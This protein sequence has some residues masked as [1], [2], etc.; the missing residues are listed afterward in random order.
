MAVQVVDQFEGPSPLAD[1]DARRQVQ[2]EHRPVAG[3]KHRGLI[4]RGEEPVGI[5]RLASLERSLGIGHDN[6]SGE[7]LTFRT[8][9]VKN[10]RADA[11]EARH[12]S[13]REQLVLGG[14]MDDHIA[15]ARPDDRDI[16][17]ARGSLW[18]EVG[19]LDAA[20][21]VLLEGATAAEQLGVALDELVLGFAELLGARLAVELIEQW[22]GIEGFEVARPSRHEQEDHRARLGLMMRRLRA[23]RA[24]R[25][26]AGLLFPQDRRQRE[27]AKSAE[28]IAHKLPARQRWAR[29][30][31][32]VKGH[33]EIH[34]Y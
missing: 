30:K 1:L 19:N 21:T 22:L 18:E 33:T 26:G 2:I 12:D 29:V 6:V 24:R 11:R 14:R 20:L 7:R 31:V 27:A 13:S 17:D 3:S 5:H 23:E 15:V 28:G 32:K 25:T 8:K 4:D 34:S 16:V 9:A 10:P